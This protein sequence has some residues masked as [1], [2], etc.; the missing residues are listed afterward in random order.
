MGREVSEL[1]SEVKPFFFI[2]ANVLKIK[3]ALN[4]NQLLCCQAVHSIVNGIASSHALSL[5][6][7]VSS[8]YA[9]ILKLG[10]NWNIP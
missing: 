5:K 4:T 3:V 8:S 1:F 2:K 7:G 9:L 6:P 10:D